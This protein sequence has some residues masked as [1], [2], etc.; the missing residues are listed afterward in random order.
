MRAQLQLILV[1]W[2]MA[3]A[4]A[5]F[6]QPNPD[7]FDYA[8][9]P[10]EEQQQVVQQ[11]ES[12]TTVAFNPDDAVLTDR[13]VLEYRQTQERYRFYEV[14]LLAGVAIFALVIVLNY[15]RNSARCQPRDMVN[16]TGLILVIFSTI[17]VILLADVEVQLTA[18]MGVLGGIA[19]YLFGTFNAP[20][21]SRRE[22][23]NREE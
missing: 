23:E 18:A 12:N 20:R 19:G 8:N 10:P 16:A 15:I 14:V 17:I 1:C 22:G 6:A 21:A 2:F 3:L 7:A 5:A 13:M 4:Q 11:A 9:L